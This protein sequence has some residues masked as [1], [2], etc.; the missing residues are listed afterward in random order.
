MK[1][2]VFLLVIFSQVTCQTDFQPVFYIQPYL[3]NVTKNKIS[4]LWWTYDSYDSNLVHYG[5]ENFSYREIASNEY[6]PAVGKFLHEV[7][8]SGLESFSQYNYY[9]Q[10]G[11]Y[12]SRK[13][14]FQ[15]AIEHD[16]NFHFVVLGDGRTDNDT[17]IAN[18]RGVT[19]LAW[20]QHPDI[21]FQLG[22]LVYSGDQV[23]WDRF[24]RRIA[25]AS[26]LIDPGPA[27]A[28]FIPYY[29]AVG[30]HEIYSTKTKYNDGN[31]DSTMVRYKAYVNVPPNNSRNPN[32]EERYYAIRFSAAKFI[33]LDTNNTSDDSLD[34]HFYL[35]DDST[36]DWEPGSEQHDWLIQQLIEAQQQSVFTF[37]MMHPAPFCRGNHGDPAEVQ[38]G[39]HIRALDPIFREYGV[40]AVFCSHDHLVERCLTGPSGF[41]QTMDDGDVNNLNYFVMGNSGEGARSPAENWCTWMD[42]LENDSEP[43]YT[44][45]FY[46]WDERDLF[47][48]IDVDI[49]NN[50]DGTW[51]ASFQ[52]IRNDGKCF[53]HISIIRNDVDM[54]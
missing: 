12:N 37:V 41:E 34:N 13:Y 24:W 49:K 38:S 21:A 45:Y 36:P 52:V 22:D 5:K 42:I 17:V 53:D 43:Y 26:D 27:F 29:F 31:L 32:W 40:D 3:Q 11:I 44:R 4:I 30:N 48:F 16:S 33:I 28:S 54:N 14:S 18:H 23:H 25:T 35:P 2:I 8:L 9:V 50:K 15:T 39:W 7:T 47:S 20:Q 51:Q 10:S 19:Q 1:R 46:D 6:I